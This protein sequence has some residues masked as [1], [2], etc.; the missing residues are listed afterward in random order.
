MS[1]LVWMIELRSRPSTRAS[2]CI[3]S[4]VRRISRNLEVL[5]QSHPFSQAE[6]KQ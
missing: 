6:T 4:A 5:G 2:A 1:N 3:R